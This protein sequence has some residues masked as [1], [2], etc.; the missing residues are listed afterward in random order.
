MNSEEVKQHVR[1]LEQLRSQTRRFHLLTTVALLAI[2]LAG[3]SAI[4]N[5][6]YSLAVPGPKQDAFVSSFTADLQQDFLPVAQKIAGRS[7]ARLKPAV[8][9]ELERLSARAPEIA[10]VAVLELDK[11]G[12]ELPVRA[13]KI[14]DQTVGATLQQREAKL[15]RM[16]PGVTDSQIAALLENLNAEAQ[17]QLAKTGEKIFKPHLDAIQNI[18]TSLDKI[19]KT[20]PTDATKETDA[21]QVA[22]LFLDVFVHEFQDL[23]VVN[24]NK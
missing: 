16:Y 17:D 15:H 20:E 6:F 2:V 21:W 14:L 5:S 10:E 19:Q 23:A 13:E 11:M 4:I 3:V 8:D 24:R 22:F 7:L 9:Q 12:N 18:L 1:E